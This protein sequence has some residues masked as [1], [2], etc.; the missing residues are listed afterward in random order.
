M[1]GREQRRQVKRSPDAES[2]AALSPAALAPGLHFVATPIGTARDITL[3]ALD[4]LRGADI[5]AAEDTRTAKRLLEIHGIPLAGRPLLPY[6]DHNGARMRPRLLASLQEGLRVAYVSDAGTPLV[7]DPGYQLARAAIDAGIPVTAAP[8]PSAVLAALTVSGLPTDRFLFAGFPP[9]QAAARRAW[10]SKLDAADATVVIFENPRRI[11]G[12]LSELCELVGDE[13]RGVLCRELTK[14]FEE[15]RR[16]PLAALRDSV[17]Q[18]PPKGECV[19]LLDR[20]SPATTST[21]EIET[22]LRGALEDMSVKAAAA[23][24]AKAFDVP[25]RDVYQLALRLKDEAEDD[26]AGNDSIDDGNGQ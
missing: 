13:R 26:G 21:A 5:I 3:R 1:A 23:E 17:V 10:L 16:G 9:P 11:H 24:V 6:H 2:D 14:R 4:T 18:T 19:L 15:V 22:A 7:A 25:R 8:G 20:P 12:L